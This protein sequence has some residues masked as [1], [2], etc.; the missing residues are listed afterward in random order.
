MKI[1]VVTTYNYKL[2][3]EYAHKFETSYNWPFERVVYNEDEN[4]FDLVPDCK[5]FIERNKKKMEGKDPLKDYWRDG[6]RFCYKVY[7]YTHAILTNKE[8]DG[9]ICID[10]DSV[11]YKKIDENWIKE[12][13]HKDDCMMTYLGR[14]D[15]YSE[16]GFLYFNMK[17]PKT[18]RYAERMKEMYDTDGIYSLAQQ[19]DSWVWDHVRKQFEKSGVK[20]YDIGDGKRGHVQARSILGTIYDHTKGPSRKARGKS[21]EFNI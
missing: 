18:K 16:C 7:A 1:L 10:A 6:V 12:N 9:I 3:K 21:P 14:G 15:H 17:H 5:K 13:I 2:L 20:N 4:L 8:Y 11:F 19:H